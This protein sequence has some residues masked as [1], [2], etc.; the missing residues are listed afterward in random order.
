MFRETDKLKRVN[1]ERTRGAVRGVVGE[2]VIK[3]REFCV[4]QRR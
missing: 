1:W 4:D 3:R 2:I